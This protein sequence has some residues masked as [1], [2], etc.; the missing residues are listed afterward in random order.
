MTAGM[1]YDTCLRLATEMTHNPY[2]LV[3]YTHLPL[4]LTGYDLTSR[5]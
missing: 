5:A 1:G 4:C 3:S 2:E